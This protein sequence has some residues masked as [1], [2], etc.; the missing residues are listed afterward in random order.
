M[1]TVQPKNSFINRYYRKRSI[2][3]RKL[4]A[5]HIHSRD[6]T[7]KKK[8]AKFVETRARRV[9]SDVSK[10]LASEKAESWLIRFVSAWIH[11]DFVAQCVAS[12]WF[13]LDIYQNSH[14][15]IPPQLFFGTG[16][17]IAKALLIVVDS[18]A[19]YFIGE[20]HTVLSNLKLD[21]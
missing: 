21:Y 3:P 2:S 5:N 16:E 13:M 8:S 6:D 1:H 11:N 9:K 10:M 20:Q 17:L 19:S 15:N 7:A 4:D 18:V 12:R 14:K